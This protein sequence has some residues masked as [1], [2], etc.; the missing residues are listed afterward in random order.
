[1]ASD[2][3][4][5]N[6]ALSKLG[7]SP[8]TA[9]TDDVERARLANRIFTTIR[10]AVLRDYDWNFALKRAS[11]SRPTKSVTSI[12][13]ASQTATVTITAHGY[14]NNDFIRISGAT[15]TEYNGLFQISNVAANT[16]DYTVTGTPATPATG[17]ILAELAP[18]FEFTYQYTL[19]TDY[20]RV[21]KINDSTAKW[22]VENG[23]LL[24]DVTTIKLLYVY[25][26]T[27]TTKFD[28]SFV[29][30]MAARMA[31]EMAIPLNRGDAMAG[32]WQLYDRK[33]REC[34][35]RDL[36]EESKYTQD[37]TVLTE[38]R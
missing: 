25:K 4:I 31:A 15:Q 19:P 33:I 13:R 36:Q 34:R 7:Q 24:A 10:D 1:M 32:M 37:T 22:K 30:A 11:I 2:V 6:N 17:T 16:F 3:D 26:L 27:D 21:A 38:V 12:T 35:G 8:I 20:I 18:A 28:A 29:E 9:L 5:V 14:A 23:F